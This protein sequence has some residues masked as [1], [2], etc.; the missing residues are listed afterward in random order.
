MHQ[1]G[2]RLRVRFR[3]VKCFEVRAKAMARAIQLQSNPAIREQVEGVK[4]RASTKKQSNGDDSKRR[5]RVERR[6]G[7]LVAYEAANVVSMVE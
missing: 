5:D 1:S 2:Q 6:I 4:E 3:T 7:A